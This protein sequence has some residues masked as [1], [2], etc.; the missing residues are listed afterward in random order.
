MTSSPTSSFD[1][2]LGR[3]PVNE[4]HLYSDASGSYGMVGVLMFGVTNKR[5]HAVDGSFW[6]LSWEEWRKR[7]ANIDLGS[8][9]LGIST[10]DFL[11]ALNCVLIADNSNE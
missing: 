3:L 9:P 5:K 1:F 7:C 2:F 4:D 8:E 6:Q 10:A 11:A